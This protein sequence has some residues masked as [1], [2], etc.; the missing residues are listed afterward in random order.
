MKK[1]NGL[2]DLIQIGIEQGATAVEGIH[3]D[4]IQNNFALVRNVPQIGKLASKVQ[5][6][7]MHHTGSIYSIIRL[8]NQEFGNFGK[9]LVDGVE[10]LTEEPHYL[11]IKPGSPQTTALKDDKSNRKY[12]DLF[13]SIVNGVLGDFLQKNQNGLALPMEFYFQNRPLCLTRKNIENVYHKTTSKICIMV[14]GL[15]CNEKTWEFQSSPATTYG[16]LLQ[17]DLGYTPFFV[18]YNTGLHISENGRKFSALLTGLLKAYPK[19]VEEIV[20]I[21]HSMGGLVIRSGCWYG[22]EEQADW[23]RHVTKIVYLATPHLGAPFEKFGNVLSG[24]LK[25]IPI[26]YIK[27]IADIINVRSSGIKDL[28]FGNVVDEDWADHDPDVILKNHK[29]TI[30]LLEGASHYAISGSLNSDPSHCFTRLIG[31]PM[32][33]KSSAL[34]QSKQKDQHIDFCGYREFSEVGHIR[35]AHCRRVYEQIKRWCE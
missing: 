34:G 32:V 1:V 23:T 6:I 2:L 22:Q 35:M 28:R 27:V 24:V 14:H 10:K 13:V 30:P 4:V 26:S 8:V 12:A 5:D 18:R 9:L 7:H 25:K 11:S 20:I 33:Q 19:E 21:G 3:A 17:Q 31:D 29:T 15:T 16:T